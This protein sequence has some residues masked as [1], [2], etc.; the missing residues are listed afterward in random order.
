MHSLTPNGVTGHRAAS[1]ARMT[2]FELDL[3]PVRM[4]VFMPIQ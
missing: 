3:E 1:L 2:V 4:A